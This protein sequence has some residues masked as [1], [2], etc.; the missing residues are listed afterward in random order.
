METIQEL[1]QKIKLNK[2]ILSSSL[3]NSELE[4]RNEISNLE[5]F[6]DSQIIEARKEQKNNCIKMASII[7][8]IHYYNFLMYV[9]FG[10]DAQIQ[11]THHVQWIQ[12]KIEK[13]YLFNYSNYGIEDKETGLFEFNFNTMKELLG[14]VKSRYLELSNQYEVDS[15]DEIDADV[16]N[17]QY[18]DKLLRGE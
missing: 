8:E 1:N 5:Q 7:S 4:L 11:T 15:I 12:H 2:S 17:K 14:D 13:N 16:V 3:K 10:F 6:R 18:V 9:Q